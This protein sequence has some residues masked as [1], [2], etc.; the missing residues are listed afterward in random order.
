MKR[1]SVEDKLGKTKFV[2]DESHSHIVVDKEY[3]DREEVQRL[4]NVCPAGLYKLDEQ[5]NLQFSYLGCLECGT[6]RALSLGKV[7]TDWNYPNDGYG[8][9]FRLG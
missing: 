6:C 3:L 8:V 4:V 1:M 5:G 9:S 2:V 7:I